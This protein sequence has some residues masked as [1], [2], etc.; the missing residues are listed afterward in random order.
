M[1]E[2]FLGNHITEENA[3]RS[4]EEEEEKREEYK[5]ERG[6]GPRISPLTQYL[7]KENVDEITDMLMI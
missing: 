6:H 1:R 2:I 7:A 4:E 3:S 5:L